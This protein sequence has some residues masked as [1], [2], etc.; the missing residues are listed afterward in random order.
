MTVLTN[1]P[2]P[3]F[4]KGG[5][6]LTESLRRTR[7]QIVPEGTKNLAEQ[8]GLINVEMRDFFLGLQKGL[9]INRLVVEYK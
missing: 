1:H 6:C 4:G 5:E 2:C 3:S 8:T 7:Q 9:Y